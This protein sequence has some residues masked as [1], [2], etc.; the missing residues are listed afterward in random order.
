MENEFAPGTETYGLANLVEDPQ[1]EEDGW[2]VTTESMVRVDAEG[3]WHSALC[4]TGPAH[5]EGRVLEFA[6]TFATSE[7]AAA[8]ASAVMDNVRRRTA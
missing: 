3:L 4:I 6:E 5:P 7:D 2:V 1:L 8:H